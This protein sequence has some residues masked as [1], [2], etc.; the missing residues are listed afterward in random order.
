[1]ASDDAIPA[2]LRARLRIHSSGLR[3]AYQFGSSLDPAA[4][5]NDIDLVLVSADGAGEPAWRGT[6]ALAAEL[7]TAFRLVFRT[8]LSVMVLTPS[9]WAELDGVIVRERRSLLG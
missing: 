9:E 8:Q 4:R 2:W 5:P 6:I 1:M 7:R 3:A